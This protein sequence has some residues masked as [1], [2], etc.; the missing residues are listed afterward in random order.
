M[1]G[2]LVKLVEWRVA[3]LADL[4]RGPPLVFLDNDGADDL[5]WLVERVDIFCILRCCKKKKGT[6]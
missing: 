1:V 2:L 6:R 4:G 5:A 3:L